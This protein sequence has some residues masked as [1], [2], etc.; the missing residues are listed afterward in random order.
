MHPLWQNSPKRS[1][2][3]SRVKAW[4]RGGDDV[5]A[6]LEEGEPVKRSY[7]DGWHVWTDLY[8]LIAMPEEGVCSNCGKKYLSPEAVDSTYGE[9]L[10]PTCIGR[11]RDRLYRL[12][13][14]Q[15]QSCPIDTAAFV[16]NPD[17]HVLSYAEHEAR[18]REQEK[19]G[20]I[21]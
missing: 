9:E 17:K 3:G 13:R 15:R 10:C 12:E 19:K 8:V 7:G 6:F 5:A 21:V 1:A 14:G 2:S 16:F 18:Q 20:R 4:L 11:I